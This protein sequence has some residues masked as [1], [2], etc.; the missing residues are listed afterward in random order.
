MA[1]IEKRRFYTVE[2]SWYWESA[3]NTP[4]IPLHKGDEEFTYFRFKDNAVEH[5]KKLRA[6]AFEKYKA[7]LEVNPNMLPQ[8][9]YDRD[10]LFEWFYHPAPGEITVITVKIDMDEFQDVT[11]E[12]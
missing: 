2:R 7:L 4:G 9:A 5:F 10:Y 1:N 12:D 3:E 8:I 11:T 6:E